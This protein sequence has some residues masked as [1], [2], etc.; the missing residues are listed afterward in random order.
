M[1]STPEILE[2][3]R[4][5]RADRERK[6]PE[7]LKKRELAKKLRAARPRKRFSANL[8]TRRKWEEANPDYFREWYEKV[9]GRRLYEASIRDPAKIKARNALQYAVRSGKIVRR[10][11]ERCGAGDAHGHHEDYSKPFEVH[12]LCRKCH[13]AHHRRVPRRRV[14]DLFGRTTVQ[15]VHTPS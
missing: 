13:D 8:E 11:C 7:R 2:K 14:V 10:P 5:I 3:W 4:L 12:W 15:I 9:G 1:R 6:R